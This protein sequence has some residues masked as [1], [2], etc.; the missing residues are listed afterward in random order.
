MFELYESVSDLGHYQEKQFN[1]KGTI[2]PEGHKTKVWDKHSILKTLGK[3]VILIESQSMENQ[4]DQFE[5]HCI[6]ITT[7]CDSNLW[8]TGILNSFVLCSQI[9]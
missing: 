8:K 7:K 9:I 3:G 2:I 6:Q 5:E 1:K 4:L